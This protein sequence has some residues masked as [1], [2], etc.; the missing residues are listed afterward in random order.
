MSM[1]WWATATTTTRC[2]GTSRSRALQPRTAL[3]QTHANQ[4]LGQIEAGYRIGIFAPAALSLT[5]FARLQASTGTQAGFTETG[6]NSLNLTVAQ[7][8]TD[9]LRSTFGVD[10]GGAI[11]AG[12]REKLAFRVR[13]GWAHEYADTSRPMTAAFAGRSGFGFT[14]LGAAP[15]RD[16]A[17]AR[18]WSQHRRCRVDV[19]LRS[20]RRRGRRQQRQPRLQ[21]R[22]A[23]DVV[24][25]WRTAGAAARP[26][27]RRPVSIS[28]Q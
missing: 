2:A 18:P 7:Q 21:R 10:L 24:D 23:H 15:Q 25:G 17:V 27:R 20:L 6:A 9:A 8:T 5:P 28:Y 3:G 1:R 13:L 11:D 26:L 4:F 22:I 12:W 19:D 16:S 14:V